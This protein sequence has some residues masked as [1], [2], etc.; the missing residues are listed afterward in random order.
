MT[1]EEF[2]QKRA[3]LDEKYRKE[4][5]G[6][7]VEYAKSYNAFSV[8]QVVQMKRGWLACLRIEEIKHFAKE[9]GEV[10]T[11]LFCRTCK[12]DGSDYKQSHKATINDQ[13]V[14]ATV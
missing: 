7:Q 1:L 5:S 8:G 2:N 12:K 11:T 4:L 10:C 3:I 13:D 14:K 6:L 9:N